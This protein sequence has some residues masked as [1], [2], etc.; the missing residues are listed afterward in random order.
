MEPERSVKN[1]SVME[2][3]HTLVDRVI[4]GPAAGAGGA[5][6]ERFLK[7]YGPAVYRYLLGAL[8]QPD[9]ADEL[10]QEFALRLVRGDLQRF[11]PGRGRFRW[12][13]KTVLYHLVVDYQRRRRGPEPLDP[14]RHAPAVAPP[15]EF[16]SDREFTAAWRA[17]LLG[18][19][20]EALA[21]WERQSGQPLYTVLRLRTERPELRSPQLAEVLAGQLGQR[22]SPEW[23][24]KRL[25]QAREKFTAFVLDQVAQS[26]PGGSDEELTREVEELGLLDYCRDALEKR[27]KQA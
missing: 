13:L 10:F 11:D 12:Y 25:F 14:E 17:E 26:L 3:A 24:R 27:R 7:V 15:S 2:T 8:R 1:I 16:E 21:A 19:A 5:D 22:V 9:A 4:R 23:V 20:W 18:R 6:Q